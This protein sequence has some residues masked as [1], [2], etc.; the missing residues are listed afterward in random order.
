[1][2]RMFISLALLA[3]VLLGATAAF[4][5]DQERSGSTGATELRIPVGARA[6][7]IAGAV[8]A[9]V[10]GVDALFWN[11]AG[12]AHLEAPQAAYSYT[13][14]FADMKLNWLGFASPMAGGQFGASL[15]VL[16]IG[17]L[18]VTTEDAPNGTGE[19]ISP[20]FA[21]VGVSYAKALTDRVL[22]GTTFNIIQERLLQETASGVGFDMGF[23]YLLGAQGLQFGLAIKNLGPKMH[24]AGG[25]LESTFIPSD[26]DPQSRR[27]TFSASSSAFELPSYVSIGVSYRAFEDAQ[28]SLLLNGDFQSNSFSGDEYR[29]GAEYAYRAGA[30]GSTVLHIRGGWN[31]ANQDDFLFS[32][33]AFGL[34]LD[35]RV[36]TDAAR[37]EYARNFINGDFRDF[38]DDLNTLTL[39][40]SF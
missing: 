26:A 38:F 29:G 12:L 22:V 18:I 40:Y 23:Q 11:P 3:A 15:K 36:G 28:S 7:S 13:D 9:D 1:M 14:Y 33:G 10:D 16:S 30:A 4:A 2:R 27:R 6:N 19:V 21:V 39:T 32:G 37:I 8:V 34:G 20:N 31:A 35:F 5:G 25:D 24:Y 17:D